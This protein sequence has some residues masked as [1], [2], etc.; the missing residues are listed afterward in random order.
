MKYYF[1]VLERLDRLKWIFRL[2]AHRHT[3]LMRV[4][5]RQYVALPAPQ[6]APCQVVRL[7]PPS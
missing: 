5:H 3:I 7:V 1:A 2:V 6:R 4:N